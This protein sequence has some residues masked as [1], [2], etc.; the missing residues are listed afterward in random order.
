MWTI[1]RTLV[2]QILGHAQR[3]FP[4]E[5]VGILSGQGRTML[6]WHPL[7]NRWH[8]GTR[9]SADAAEL[10]P[11]LRQLREEG[12]ALVAIYHSHP[13]TSAVPSPTDI[14]QANHPDALHLIVSLQTDGRLEMNGYLIQDNQPLLQAVTVQG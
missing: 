12:R 1:P 13:Q 9:F 8:D 14:Q 4:E 5:C 6:G 10:I 3:C 11:L 2:N 7:T